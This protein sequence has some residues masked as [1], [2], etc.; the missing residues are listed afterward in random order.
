MSKDKKILMFVI[1]GVCVC[2]LGL[3]AIAISY[4]QKPDHIITSYSPTDPPHSSEDTYDDESSSDP[5]MSP[6]VKAAMKKMENEIKFKKWIDGQFS[7]WDGSHNALVVLVKKN[8]NDPGSFKH[9]KTVYFEHKNYI[10]IVMTYRAKNAFGGLILQNV[11]AKSDY[12]TN[13][14]KIISQND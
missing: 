6:E 9:D 13:T 2:F 8:L 4:N 10:T 14:I 1:I 12:K 5:T 11:T 7:I 3:I